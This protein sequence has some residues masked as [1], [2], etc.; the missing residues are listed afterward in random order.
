MKI[1]TFLEFVWSSRQ[2]RY[3]LVRSQSITWTGEVALCKSEGPSSEQQGLASSQQSFYNTLQQSY[4]T[5]FAGKENILNTLNKSLSPIINAGVGQ[6]GFGNAEDASMRNQAT[7]GTAGAYK[8]A[9]QA[10]GEAQAAQGGGDTFIGSGV[11][12]QTNAQLANSAASTEANQQLGITQQGYQQGRQNYFGAVGQEQKVADAYDPS[13]LASAA[14]SAGTSA[15]GSASGNQQIKAAA[16]AAN[17][18]WAPIGGALGGIAGS[19]VGQPAAGEAL[20]SSLGGM[21]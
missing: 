17:N 16:D 14:N 7:A 10:T 3:I 1:N 19:F 5:V 11:K 4:G 2:N 21:A 9:K 18:P 13:G 6:Y 20:G 8:S 15:Y 12:A